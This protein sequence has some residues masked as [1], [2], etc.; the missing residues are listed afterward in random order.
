MGQKHPPKTRM[1]IRVGVTGHRLESLDAGFDETLLRAAI[2]EVLAR[3]RDT[4]AEILGE[5]KDVYSPEPP[6]LRVI[7]PLAEGADRFVAEEAL[8]LGYEIQ[9]PLPFSQEEYEEDFTREGSKARFRYLLGRASAVLALD[10]SRQDDKSKSLAYE[11]A[12]RVVLRQ[13]DLLIAIW[14]GEAAKGQ[15]G[16]GQIV[17]EALNRKI[18]TIWIQPSQPCPAVFLE[19]IS[20]DG[21]AISSKKFDE[22][23]SLRS[24]RNAKKTL[25]TRGYFDAKL[26]EILEISSPEQL[27]AFHRFLAETPPGIRTAHVY[28]IFCKIFVPSWGSPS[29]RANISETEGQEEWLRW[30]KPQTTSHGATGIH[31]E[32]SYRMPF[33]WSDAIADVYVDRYRSS[34]ITTYMLG[35]LAVLAAFLGAHPGDLPTLISGVI[36]HSHD[37]FKVELIFISGILL[38]VLLN[39]L[40]RWRERWIDYRLLAEGLRQMRALA[41]FARVTPSFEVPAHLSE[42][43][44]SSTWFNWYF[45]SIVRAAGLVNARVDSTY[46]KICRGVL[47][48]EILSQTRYHRR[49]AERHEALHKRLHWLSILLFIATLLAC[50]AH[51]FIEFEPQSFTNGMLT[52]FAI[53]LPAFGAAIQGIIHQGEFG[54]IARRSHAIRNRL[55]EI[56]RQ[57]RT[58]ERDLSFR[59]LGRITESFSK[60]QILEQADWRSVFIIKEVSLP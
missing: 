30:W 16:T 40:G 5:S 52:L 54:R 12:G 41:P 3:I 27:E 50:L 42:D 4:T 10:G 37:W 58:A 33:V 17:Q 36:H 45:R 55:R 15:G 57:I 53:V 6:L 11:A 18:P 31:I 48:S 43:V 44:S 13:S 22:P 23:V 46:L 60:I 7:S 35:A 47:V 49:T 19:K 20:E 34:F 25:E 14:N 21:L 29:W 38:L 59:D 24:F 8:E 32:Q 26:R 1:A 2:R 51:L 9:S 28:R 39:K 56:L